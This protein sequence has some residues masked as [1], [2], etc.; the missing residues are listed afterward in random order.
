L[1]STTTLLIFLF[2]SISVTLGVQLDS[3][4]NMTNTI[5]PDKA[6]QGEIAKELPS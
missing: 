4:A 5:D 3:F 1:T 2:A 6:N